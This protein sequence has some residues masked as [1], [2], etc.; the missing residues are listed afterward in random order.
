LIIELAIESKFGEKPVSHANYFGTERAARYPKWCTVNLAE[1]IGYN[2]YPISFVKL[3]VWY[4]SWPRD[5]G[6]KR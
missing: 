6:K 2:Q 1:L 3:C 5:A 4:A